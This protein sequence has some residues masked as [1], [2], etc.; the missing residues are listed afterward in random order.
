MRF[1][2]L[3]PRRLRRILIT[4]PD[5]ILR[6]VRLR[7]F[8]VVL[9]VLR[10]INPSLQGIGAPKTRAGYTPIHKLLVFRHLNKGVFS[11]S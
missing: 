7:R 3:A 6:F 11:C 5:R 1:G 8:A 4:R 9:R 2:V 10:F